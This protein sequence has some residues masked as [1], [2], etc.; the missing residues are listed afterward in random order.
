MCRRSPR[1]AVAALALLAAVV[2][3]GCSSSSKAATPT[4]APTTVAPGSAAGATDT[5]ATASARPY[6]VGTRT[7]TWVDTSRPTKGDAR[8][9]IAASTSRRL[10]VLILYP[11]AGKAR[12]VTPG[13]AAA[14]GRFPLVV[15]SHG[16][17]A[18]GPAYA[19]FLA[20]W[21]AAGYVVAAPTY[22]MTSG[23]GAWADLVDFTNQPADVSFV[24]D[25]L[26]ALDT[27]SG[28]PLQGHLATSEIAVAG[29]SL[30]AMT[31]LGFYNSCCVDKRVKAVVAI[32]GILATFPGGTWDNPPSTPL[33]MVHGTADKTVPYKGGSA[34]TFAKFTT[35]PRALLTFIGGGHV[36]PVRAKDAPTTDRT[37]IAFLD[38]ELRDD[39]TAWH[40][41]P[42]YLDA[43]KGVHFAV[44]GGLPQP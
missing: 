40:Q 25:K 30:G 20:A 32:S 6:A 2:V 38:L 23:S 22:P 5:G 39:S 34:T 28:D 44:A 42:A 9:H 3:A 14:S 1:R 13:A 21:A 36:D 37:V 26:V 33:L 10:P 41:L 15:F 43:Q 19:P 27:T 11:A 31:S 12:S 18:S 8:R 24:I 7:V 29:H 4:S 16:V 17:T 35:V